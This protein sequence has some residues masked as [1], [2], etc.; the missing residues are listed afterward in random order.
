MPGHWWVGWYEGASTS[1]MGYR[2]DAVIWI[3]PAC[4]AQEW[5]ARIMDRR[6]TE[7]SP[8]NTFSG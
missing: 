3:I 6:V 1:G 8:L 5:P 4:E 2:A 7:G